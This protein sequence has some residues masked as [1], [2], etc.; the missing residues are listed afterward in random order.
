MLFPDKINTIA[1]I[2]AQKMRRKS[3]VKKAKRHTGNTGKKRS[4]PHPKQSS[5]PPK[6]TLSALKRAADLFGKC[7]IL[8]QDRKKALMYG[9]VAVYGALLLIVGWGLGNALYAE[10]VDRIAKKPALIALKELSELYRPLYWGETHFTLQHDKIRDAVEE[11]LKRMNHEFEDCIGGYAEERAAVR[12]RKKMDFVTKWDEYVAYNEDI[13]KNVET[14]KNELLT[15][16]ELVDLENITEGANNKSIKS[17]Y[18]QYAKL[19]AYQP[20]YDISVERRKILLGDT[21]EKILKLIDDRIMGVQAEWDNKLSD[22]MSEIREYTLMP[23]AVQSV[24]NKLE[25]RFI[26]YIDKFVQAVLQDHDSCDYPA[27]FSAYQTAKEHIKHFA[28]MNPACE[29]KCG[30]LDEWI[31]LSCKIRCIAALGSIKSCRDAY[32]FFKSHEHAYS[33]SAHFKDAK[34]KIGREIKNTFE[35][36]INKAIISNIDE[37]VGLKKNVE[38]MLRGLG[39]YQPFIDEISEKIKQPLKGVYQDKIEGYVEAKNFEQAQKELE[40]LIGYNIV[41]KAFTDE[42]NTII[43]QEKAWGILS[44]NFPRAMENHHFP[45]II[46]MLN[47]YDKSYPND[48]RSRDLRMSAINQFIHYITNLLTDGIKSRNLDEAHFRSLLNEYVK[49]CPD[50]YKDIV[51]YLRFCFIGYCIGQITENPYSAKDEIIDRLTNESDWSECNEIH[52]KRLSALRIAALQYLNGGDYRNYKLLQERI[53]PVELP[54]IYDICI[55]H[56]HVSLSDEYYA[57]LKGAG[58]AE[59]RLIIKL[60]HHADDKEGEVLF[61]ND[62]P[63][64]Q[65]EFD[66]IVNIQGLMDIT[67]ERIICQI[68]DSGQHSPKAPSKEMT[69]T[70]ARPEKPYDCEL[71]ISVHFNVE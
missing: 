22:L 69:V 16:A 27:F 9:G 53:N 12:Q 61:R 34:E 20:H 60:Y 70:I 17:I 54:D 45:A 11:E 23:D 55:T 51:E 67:N 68:E 24:Q 13:R 42:L 6:E 62:N 41:D 43:H 28:K 48:G 26:A 47:D 38:E 49:N 57:E 39:D 50:H 1:A 3:T 66:V 31:E 40:Q 52:R 25:E 58:S 33:Q 8:P 59:S 63:K 14:L 46:G 21:A 5:R 10:K 32:D 44:E 19:H 37:A 36:E 29:K 15:E 56:V 71:P 65:K 35:A 2:R 4:A 18:E 30:E 7:N 64:D